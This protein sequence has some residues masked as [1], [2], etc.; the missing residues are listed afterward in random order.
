V[1][2]KLIEYSNELISILKQGHSKTCE[3][4]I[5]NEDKPWSRYLTII[6]SIMPGEKN[7]ILQANIVEEPDLEEDADENEEELTN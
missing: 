7:K 6:L 2:S 4:I 3:Y 5:S 1:L